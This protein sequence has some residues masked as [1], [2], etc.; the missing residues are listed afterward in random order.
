MTKKDL[1]ELMAEFP[2]STELS[3]VDRA[4]DNYYTLE[5]IY[6]YMGTHNYLQLPIVPEND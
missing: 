3:F 6:V 1:F 4:N 5:G 2:D